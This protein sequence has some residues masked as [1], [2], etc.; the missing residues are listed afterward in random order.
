MKELPS[1]LKYSKIKIINVFL[2][3]YIFAYIYIYYI[4]RDKYTSTNISA[5]S[6]NYV[7]HA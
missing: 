4:E 3:I 1:I 2:V 5:R 7:N 6:K